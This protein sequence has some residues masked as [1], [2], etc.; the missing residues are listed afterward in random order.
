MFIGMIQDHSPPVYFGDPLCNRQPEPCPT[1]V[2]IQL[3]HTRLVGPVESFKN[4]GLRLCRD[5]TPGILN[6]N[7]IHP[8]LAFGY[9]LD[10]SSGGRVFDRIIKQ[11]ND[12][13][14]KQSFIPTEY[15]V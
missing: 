9:E 6:A 14:S 12:H 1:A 2:G 11:I 3:A 4:L 7:R 8:A 13:S 5:T 15:Q 10:V